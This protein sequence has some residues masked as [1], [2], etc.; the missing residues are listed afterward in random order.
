MAFNHLLWSPLIWNQPSARAPG[1]LDISEKRFLSLISDAVSGRRGCRGG[2]GVALPVAAGGG[3]A[4]PQGRGFPR[5][6]RA[7]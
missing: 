7:F 1:D 3:E 5:S 4:A 2:T 6:R